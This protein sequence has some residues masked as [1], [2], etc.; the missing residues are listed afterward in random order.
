M[1]ELLRDYT[2]SGD[3]VCDPFCGS[4]TTG[5]AAIKLGRQFI[6]I[7]KEPKWFD[8]SCRRIEAALKQPDFFV[9]TPARIKQ[10]SML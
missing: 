3:V 6:G 2:Q 10:E 1:A 5:I 7:E 8:L 9:S 4:G